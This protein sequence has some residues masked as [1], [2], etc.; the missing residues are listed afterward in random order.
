MITTLFLATQVILLD[1]VLSGDNAVVIAMAASVLP[2]AQRQR[3][4]YI[5]MSAAVIL[6]IALCFF[7][8][9]LLAF[10]YMK[11]IGGLLL[12]WIAYKMYTEITVDATNEP[13]DSI[14]PKA[15][16]TLAIGQIL[17]ADLSM[18][19]D[20]ILAVAALAQNHP[21][22]MVGGLI[23]SIGFVT[24]ATTMVV[25]LIDKYSWIKYVGLGLILYV[26]GNM[27]YNSML[28]FGLI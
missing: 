26:A 27:I 16:F 13:M 22:I 1:I 11:L 5:G 24:I 6:R 7:A 2:P 25:K 10:S 17:I 21:Y 3:A 20:N 15:A 14:F 8:I 18:S 19:L 9:Q 28:G 4:I 23:L 12:L